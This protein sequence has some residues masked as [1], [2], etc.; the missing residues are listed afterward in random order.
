MTDILFSTSATAFYH[1]HAVYSRAEKMERIA[2]SDYA[3]SKLKVC[4]ADG[5]FQEL[6]AM[7]QVPSHA[8]VV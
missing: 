2:E 7:Q 4:F 8:V 3:V 6:L 5:T 1:D